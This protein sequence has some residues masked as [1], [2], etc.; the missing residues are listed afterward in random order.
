MR[1]TELERRDG[2][3]EK[4]DTKRREAVR[5]GREVAEK[6]RTNRNRER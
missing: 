6:D 1:Q 2:Y 3:R 4:G 5:D